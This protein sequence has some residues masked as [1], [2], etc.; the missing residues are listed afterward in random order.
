MSLFCASSRG[1]S[2]RNSAPFYFGRDFKNILIFVRYLHLVVFIAAPLI[3]EMFEQSCIHQANPG[4]LFVST[5]F[6]LLLFNIGNPHAPAPTFFFYQLSLLRALFAAMYWIC[7]A[8]A[9]SVYRITPFYLAAVSLYIVRMLGNVLI[10][11]YHK[12]FCNIASWT[13]LMKGDIHSKLYANLRWGWHGF[14]I[15]Q[16]LNVCFNGAAVSKNSTHAMKTVLW[17][18]YAVCAAYG[19]ISCELSERFYPGEYFL[20]ISNSFLL[21]FLGA[22]GMAIYAAVERDQ[23]MFWFTL[24]YAIAFAGLIA[25]TRFFWYKNKASNKVYVSFKASAKVAATCDVPLVSVCSSSESNIHGDEIISAVSDSN[26]DGT[27]ASSENGTSLFLVSKKE[28]DL[29]IDLERHNLLVSKLFIA[30]IESFLYFVLVFAVQVVLVWIDPRIADQF[31]PSV[32]FLT[33]E[34]SIGNILDYIGN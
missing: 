1:F 4:S 33:P 16:S 9:V 34:S 28:N 5:T 6:T 29:V 22:V 30:M 10:F 12:Q 26:A 13:A 32:S 23:I 7:A 18:V 17:I 21:C 14:N 19:S 11:W 2:S 25:F 3:F 15:F 31:C 8:I 20:H 27:L 24:G